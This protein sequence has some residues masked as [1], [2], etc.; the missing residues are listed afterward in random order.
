MIRPFNP[1]T[2][3]FNDQEARVILQ[4]TSDDFKYNIVVFASL[5]DKI[6]RDFC[7]NLNS[8]I[9]ARYNQHRQ[10][11]I[12][13]AKHNVAISNEFRIRDTDTNLPIYC[14]DDR[15]TTPGTHE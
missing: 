2:V 12:I 15:D 6:A 10:N 13:R 14:D 1:F 8:T 3:E 5:S 4:N 11:E 9:N 7:N